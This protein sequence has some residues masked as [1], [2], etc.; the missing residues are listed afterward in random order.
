MST[1]IFFNNNTELIKYKSCK[2]V[3]KDLKYQ[4]KNEQFRKVKWTSLVCLKQIYKDIWFNQTWLLINKGSNLN[5]VQNWIKLIIVYKHIL[6]ENWYILPYSVLDNYSQCLII[7]MWRIRY[8]P[9]IFETNIEKRSPYI[10][11][12]MVYK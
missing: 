4:N 11:N 6:S 5:N 3:S 2:K 12:N 9:P 1:L 7:H 8:P 10:W